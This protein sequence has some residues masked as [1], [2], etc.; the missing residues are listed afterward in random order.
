MSKD[1]YIAT[2]LSSKEENA[3]ISLSQQPNKK[4]WI[5]ILSA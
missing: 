3:F 2:F 4:K 1:T 5:K